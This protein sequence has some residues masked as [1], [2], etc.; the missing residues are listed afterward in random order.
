MAENAPDKAPKNSQ[1]RKKPVKLKNLEPRFEEPAGMQWGTFDSPHSGTIRYGHIKPEGEVKGSIVVL[2]GRTEFA[3]KYYETIRDLTKRGYEVWTMDWYGQGG[4][5]RHLDNPLKDHKDDYANDVAD[6]HHFMENVFSPSTDG[7][8]MMTAHSMGGHIG[9]RYLHDHPGKFDCAAV[10]SPMLD[11]HTAPFPK[12][13]ARKLA[14]LAEKFGQTDKYIIGGSDNEHGKGNYAE[15]KV[16]TDPIRRMVHN[17]WTDKKPEL[18]LGS[19]TFGWLNETFKS[20][21]IVYDA[22]YLKAIK[23]PVLIGIGM[24]DT[25]VDVPAQQR[26]GKILPNA[27]TVEITGAR[28]EIWMESDAKRN[29]WIKAFD[30]FT[31]RHMAPKPGPSGNPKKKPPQNKRRFWRRMMPGM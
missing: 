13:M 5:E 8:V 21:D 30:D 22:D 19:P 7:P 18:A 25:V 11:I 9:L 28:H 16:S 29:K 24:D 20:I 10:T 17:Y 3:E 1:P 15:E 2:P 4:S 6:L 27:T 12:S 14:S 23:T 31:A 26:A